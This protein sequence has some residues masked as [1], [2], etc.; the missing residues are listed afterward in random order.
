MATPKFAND[1]YHFTSKELCHS[2]RARTHTEPELPSRTRARRRKQRIR[3][4]AR[5]RELD[6]Q[7]KIPFMNLPPELRNL[8]Y[9][10]LLFRANNDQ[11]L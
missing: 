8:V 2:L 6:K 7:F 9:E 5:L 4:M 1:Y 3:Y 11:R 10:A